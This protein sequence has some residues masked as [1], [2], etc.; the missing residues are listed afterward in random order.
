MKRFKR[1]LV[2]LLI[3]H[4]PFIQWLMLNL[5][6]NIKINIIDLLFTNYIIDGF[7]ALIISILFFIYLCYSFYILKDYE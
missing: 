6:F 3:L 7:I 5:I 1:I 2:I 4:I